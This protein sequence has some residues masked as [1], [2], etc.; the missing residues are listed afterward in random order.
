MNSKAARFYFLCGQNRC[1]SQIAEAF[2]KYYG[3]EHIVVES[4]GLEPS[5]TLHPFTIEVMQEVGIDL[6][7]NVSKKIDMNFFISANAI[8]K[9]CE[10]VVE[11]CP[12]VPFHIRNEEW[13]ITDPLAIEGCTLQDVR[14]AR[15]EIREKVIGLLKGMKI[16]VV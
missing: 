13:N 12:I 1:R 16:P 11:R 9:L 2:A 5:N 14:A 7:Q 10:Q 15:D 3:G 6:S 4:A 8:V